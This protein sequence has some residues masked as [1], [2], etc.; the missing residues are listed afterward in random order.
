MS[1]LIANELMASSRL[2]C[3]CAGWTSTSPYSVSAYPPVSVTDAQC[4]AQRQ[5]ADLIMRHLDGS[6]AKVRLKR[7]GKDSLDMAAEQAAKPAAATAHRRRT[8]K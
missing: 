3:S 5:H 6:L 4:K 8:S 2:L 7:L 1:R